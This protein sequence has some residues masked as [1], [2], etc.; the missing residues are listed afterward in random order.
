MAKITAPSTD[1]DMSTLT[2]STDAP[3]D[4]PGPSSTIDN[5]IKALREAEEAYTEGIER[6]DGHRIGLPEGMTIP[7]AIRALKNIETDLETE[8]QLKRDFHSLPLDGAV[9]LWKAAKETFGVMGADASK[10]DFCEEPPS[11]V[12]VQCSA[13]PKDRISIPWGKI[14]L[15]HGLGGL[16]TSWDRSTGNFKVVAKI[17]KKHQALMESLFDRAQEIIDTDSIYRG[18]SIALNLS[19]MRDGAQF[20]PDNHQPRFLNVADAHED[21]CILSE[22]VDRAVRG[23]LYSPIS[24]QD[25]ISDI[26]MRAKRVALLAGKAG[27]GKTTAGRIAANKAN[28][29]GRT[30]LLLEDTRDL[31]YAIPIAALYDAVIF[32]EDIDRIT[33]GD[34]TSELDRILNVLDG[35]EFKASNIQVIFTTNRPERINPYMIRPGRI[36]DLIVFETPDAAAAARLVAHYGNRYLSPDI[37]LDACGEATQGQI[38]A[39]IESIVQKSLLTALYHA[40]EGCSAA[41]LEGKVTT[42]D[43]V[44]TAAAMKPHID[45]VNRED[46]P[47]PKLPLDTLVRDL[48]TTAVTD[49]NQCTDDNGNAILEHM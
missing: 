39:V 18:K 46:K 24:R 40:P 27:T 47:E 20:N 14:D 15:P 45:L 25:I 5:T 12:S 13:D 33:E 41:D 3:L 10:D 37:D 4:R 11:I 28:S 2:T 36:D 32:C 34:R 1:T 44:S 43:I 19:W 9:A 8:V 6:L 26:G 22:N 29:V 30:Y 35:V 21:D 42:E 23:L 48:V 16:K 17:R 31:P 7:S 38:P 49:I